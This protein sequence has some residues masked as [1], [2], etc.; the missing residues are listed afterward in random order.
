MNQGRFLAASGAHH[1]D[2]PFRRLRR[3]GVFSLLVSAPPGARFTLDA[4]ILH[5]D[6]ADSLW[7][8]AGAFAPITAPG[9]YCLPLDDLREELRNRFSVVGLPATASIRVTSLP[10]RWGFGAAVGREAAA[11][12]SGREARTA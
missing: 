7:E 11:E 10:P 8:L 2:P 3:E 1:D 6:L 5:R 9:M 12:S 4:R